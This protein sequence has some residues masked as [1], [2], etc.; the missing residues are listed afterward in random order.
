MGVFEALGSAPLLCARETDATIRSA[1]IL[2]ILDGCP[3]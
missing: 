1:A 3:T 2:V